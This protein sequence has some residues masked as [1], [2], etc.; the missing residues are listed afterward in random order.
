M[1]DLAGIQGGG[2]S[3]TRSCAILFA[4]VLPYPTLHSPTSPNPT[5]S[6]PNPPHQTYRLEVELQPNHDI[7]LPK[8]VLT[9]FNQMNRKFKYSKKPIEFMAYILGH[10]EKWR[11]KDVTL[12]THL[13][14]PK[15]VRHLF[16][17]SNPMWAVVAPR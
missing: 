10:K 7:H 9:N 5:A 11:G 3:Q 14:V 16:Y 1:G 2:R 13:F 6:D 15:Q 17:A 12:A 4:Y 8:S